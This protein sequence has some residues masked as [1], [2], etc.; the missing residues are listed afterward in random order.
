MPSRAGETPVYTVNEAV[1]DL[2]LAAIEEYAKVYVPLVDASIKA[3][4]GKILAESPTC[5]LPTAIR[6]SVSAIVL[7]D[8]MEQF[9]AWYNSAEYRRAREIGGKYAKFRLVAVEKLPQKS[10]E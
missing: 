6:Q 10:V 7:W 4:G 5:L 2:D 1:T 9:Q 8:N 3:H